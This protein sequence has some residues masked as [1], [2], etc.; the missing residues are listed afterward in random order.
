[1]AERVSVEWLISQGRQ[2]NPLASQQDQGQ[3]VFF[4]SLAGR[5]FSALRLGRWKTI[6]QSIL[7]TVKPYGLVWSCNLFTI[8]PVH[9]KQI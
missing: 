5:F 1:M 6:A 8:Q 2:A 4:L 3:L 7:G 9:K